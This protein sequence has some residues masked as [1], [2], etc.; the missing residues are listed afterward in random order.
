MNKLWHLIAIIAIASILATLII[1][2]PYRILLPDRNNAFTILLIALDRAKLA[3]AVVIA[4]VSPS[5][6]TCLHLPRDIYT[7]NGRKLNARYRDLGLEGF[8]NLC[9]QIVGHEID[10]SVVFTLAS[11]RESL[12]LLFPAGLKIYVPRDLK[13]V[14]NHQDLRYHIPK[15][16]QRLKGAGLVIFMRHRK[17]YARGDLDR[18]IAWEIVGRAAIKELRKQPIRLVK[19]FPRLKGMVNTDLT[20]KDLLHFIRSVHAPIRFVQAPGRPFLK[21]YGARRIWFYQLNKGATRQLARLSLA[22]VYIPSEAELL[23]LNGTYVEGLASKLAQKLKSEMGFPHADTGNYPS[24]VQM[25]TRILYNDDQLRPAA[26]FVSELLGINSTIEREPK[27][28]V[29]PPRVTVIAGFDALKA[30]GGDR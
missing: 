18:I 26:R 19:A 3:D 21:R 29:A 1:A 20:A 16:L 30:I 7:W 25:E 17:G 6:L 14:D 11:L 4:Y 22:G 28:I 24:A 9:S 23:V 15:G 13:Y 27:G 12:D 8:K 5:A 2:L 10:R